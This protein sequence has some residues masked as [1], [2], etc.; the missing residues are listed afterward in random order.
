M[1]E[2]EAGPDL[3]LAVARALGLPTRT[4]WWWTGTPLVKNPGGARGFPSEFEA[5]A[6]IK[7][8][9][10]SRTHCLRV[11]LEVTIV[12]P[13]STDANAALVLEAHVRSLG[14]WFRFASPTAPDDQFW[15]GAWVAG[16]APA[17]FPA[18]SAV[19][20]TFPLALCRLVLTMAEAEALRKKEWDA[21]ANDP[22]P[23][24]E[25]NEVQQ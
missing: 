18:Y 5:V 17:H 23:A 15:A 24:E 21:L 1:A 16:I 20:V 6:W 9:R 4:E 25:P 19:G 22:A 7:G 14:W 8:N 3:D 12:E 10:Q 11:P 2:M 13:Y